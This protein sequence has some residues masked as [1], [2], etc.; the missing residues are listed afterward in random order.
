MLKM[1]RGVI[2]DVQ[3]QLV[4]SMHIL[5]FKSIFMHTTLPIKGV[6]QNESSI[7]NLNNA[8]GPDMHWVAY[9]KSRHVFWQFRQFWT[10]EGTQTV[11]G[12]QCNRVQSHASSTLQSEQLRAALST[13]STNW[14]AI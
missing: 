9:A 1:S 12:K 2:T 4:N 5:Y 8:E 11:S 10:T 7:I 6:C 14:Q 3:K 13:I